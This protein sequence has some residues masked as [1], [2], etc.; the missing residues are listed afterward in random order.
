MVTSSVDF[1]SSLSNIDESGPH[2]NEQLVFQVA[3]GLLKRR[4]S[5]KFLHEQD[6]L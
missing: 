2:S 4:Y 5:L 1:S 3:P 6:N